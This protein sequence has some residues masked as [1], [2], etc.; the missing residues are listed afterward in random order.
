[1]GRATMSSI[2]CSINFAKPPPAQVSVWTLVA[3]AQ[4]ATLR[5]FI[6][7]VGGA[8]CAMSAH[9]HVAAKHNPHCPALPDFRTFLPHR[10]ETFLYCGKYAP[11]VFEVS[12]QHNGGFQE[13][14]LMNI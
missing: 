13:Q 10:P 6:A 1:M 5:F 4:A 2:E 8:T 11:G 7:V 9:V 14:I 3:I 12:W